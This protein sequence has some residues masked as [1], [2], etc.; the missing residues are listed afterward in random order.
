MIG[1]DTNTLAR[2][3]LQ[4][5]PQQ[6]PS[7]DEIMSS[8]TIENPGWVGVATILELV[9]VLSSKSRLDRK[10]IVK[11][12]DR[13]LLQEEI[14]IEQTETVRSACQLFRRGN[15]DFADSLIAS[16]ARA[17]GCSR[18]VTFDRKAARDAGMQLL[19]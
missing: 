2:F 11:A 16:S 3:F 10:S 18:T 4:D 6:S 19:A 15:A 14:V 5:D 1:L 17:A 8:L 9:W 12:L 13:L 7:A